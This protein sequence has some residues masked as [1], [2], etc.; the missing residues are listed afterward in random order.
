MILELKE[1]YLKSITTS[2]KWADYLAHK[3]R[4][5]DTTVHLPG[6]RLS[7]DNVLIQLSY[8]VAGYAF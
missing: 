4:L 7:P 8:L 3:R 2:E 5:G 1:S 6:S